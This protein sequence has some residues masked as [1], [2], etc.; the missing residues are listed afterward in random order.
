MV[1]A[2]LLTQCLNKVLKTSMGKL[3]L[4][5]IRVLDDSPEIHPL[6]TELLSVTHEFQTVKG[7]ETQVVVNVATICCL[8]VSLVMT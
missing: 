1:Y 6:V 7:N 4:S 5:Q 8:C 2:C 3:L